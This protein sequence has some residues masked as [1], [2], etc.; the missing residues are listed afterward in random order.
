MRDTWAVPAVRPRDAI[1]KLL[2]VGVAL[3]GISSMVSALTPDLANRSALLAGVIPIQATRT[4]HVIVFELGLLLI[5]VAFGLIR[6]RHRAW[7]LALIL[8]ALTA[9]LHLAKGLDV[10]EAIAAL[11]LFVLLIV[12]RTAFTVAGAH[13]A[14]RRAITWAAYFVL[15]G[16]L[17][18]FAAAEGVARL[19]G[20]PISLREAADQGLEALVGAPDSTSAIGLYTAIAIAIAAILWLRPVPPPDPSESRDRDAARSILRRYADD[21]LSYFTL[22]KDMTLAIANNHE[23]MLAYRVIAGVA[24]VSGDVIGSD[25]GRANLLLAFHEEQIVAGRRIAAVGLPQ[26][27]CALWEQAGLMTTYIGDEAIV[28][29]EHFSLEGRTMRKVRQ[30]VSRIE[31]EGYTMQI[32]RRRDLDP[33]LLAQLRDVSDTWLGGQGERGFSMALD[34]PWAEEHGDCVFAIALA[35]D[36]TPAAY[37]HFVPVLT[38][39][40]LSLSTMRRLADAPNGLN[41][42]ILSALFV[43]AKAEGIRRVGLNFSAF[44]RILRSDDIQGLERIAAEALM[45]GDRW[46]QLERLDAFNRKFLPVWEQRYAAYERRIDLPQAALAILAAEGFISLP[47]LRSSAPAAAEGNPGLSAV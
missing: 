32:V 24:I 30:S 10:E 20:D 45:R 21:G 27:S 46:F 9:V 13:H 11:A 26:S 40:D 23:A 15:A 4:A 41:E 44:G 7:Q 1:V 34:D 33:V 18:G 6:R 22:R 2:A 29:P 5:V 39:G 37:I 12:K 28:D 35:A 31:R 17:L 14:T 47:R 38:T 3:V 16:L 43:W 25:T 19:A 36:G 42:A 8:L